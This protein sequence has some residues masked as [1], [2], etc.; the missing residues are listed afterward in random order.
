MVLNSDQ[1]ETTQLFNQMKLMQS[2]QSSLIYECDMKVTRDDGTT[3]HLKITL[4]GFSSD[5][6]GVVDNF[7]ITCV[8]MTN[9]V[10]QK[11]AVNEAKKQSEQ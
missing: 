8:D 9:D 7:G 4:I 2:G 5:V 10:E 6:D 11:N 1:K 3:V